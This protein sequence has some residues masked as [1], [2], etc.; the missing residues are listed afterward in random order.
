MQ[1][2]TTDDV[3]AAIDEFLKAQLQAKLEPLV[4]KRDK[5]DAGIEQAI[6]IETEIDTLKT[7][8]SKSIWLEN[9]ATKMA[10]QLKFGTHISKGVHPDSKGDNVNFQINRRLP[11]G[12]AGTQLLS[13][14]ELDANGNAAALPLAAF[15]NINVAGYKLRQLIFA[16]SPALENVFSEEPELSKSY[17]MAFKRALTGDKDTAKSHERNK[18]ILWPL[19]EAIADNNYRCLTP[20]YP[21]ALTHAVYHK[22]NGS[23]FSEENKQARD[24]RKKKT[25]EQKSYVSIVNLVITKLGGANSQNVSILTAKQTGKNYLLESLPPSYERQHEYHIKKSDSDFFNNNLAYHC[26]F[27]LKNLFEVVE[28]SKNVMEIRDKR[29]QALGLIIGQIFQQAEY[30]QTH[31]PAGW[32]E[33]YQ[34]VMSQKYWLDSRRSALDGQEDF[35]LK[36]DQNDWGEEVMQYF[37]NW[38]NKQLKA[39]FSEQKMEFDDAEYGEWLREMKSAIKASQRAQQGVF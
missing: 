12:V 23:R 25:A 7:R 10:K 27:G 36:R 15:F 31:Y 1:Q 18:Q 11:E 22:I 38:L 16:D 4:K 39:K 29:K 33:E 5:V 6:K 32:S 30:I 28:S 3:T 37:A 24:N 20:L 14:P 35:R 17:Q 8:F 13:E 2:I 19:D 21:S 34:L 26:W 9:A